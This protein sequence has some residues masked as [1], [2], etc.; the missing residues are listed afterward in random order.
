MFSSYLNSFYILTIYKLIQNVF[1]YYNKVNLH[2][3]IYL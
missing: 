1:T 2:Y 3:L